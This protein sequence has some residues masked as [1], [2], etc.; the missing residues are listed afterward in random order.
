MYTHPHCSSRWPG[1]PKLH[2]TDT[3]VYGSFCINWTKTV[4][5]ENH[6]TQEDGSEVKREIFTLSKISQLKRL[7][8]HVVSK[9]RARRG[10]LE[11]TWTEEKKKHMASPP[12]IVWDRGVTRQWAWNDKR[13]HVIGWIL[14]EPPADWTKEDEMSYPWLSKSI[15]HFAVCW[16]VK[17]THI[18]NYCNFSFHWLHWKN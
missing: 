16:R 1:Q 6:F 14:E 9:T 12:L 13:N 10:Q 18:G 7:E 15:S 17:E 4:T 11:N 3:S 2:F 5:R 8:G